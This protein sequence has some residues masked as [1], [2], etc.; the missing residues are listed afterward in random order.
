VVTVQSR[1]PTVTA[2][3]AATV[4]DVSGGRCVVGIGSGSG[5]GAAGL[6]SSG[7]DSPGP[8]AVVEEYARVVKSAL[9]GDRVESELFG[10]RGFHLGLDFG[11]RPRPGVWLAALGERMVSLA[12]RLADGVL[13]NWCTPERVAAARR[14]LA[15]AAERAG[16]DPAEV[17]VAVYA[18]GALEVDEAAAL[19]GLR[20]MT[21]MYASFPAY[22]RQFAA[23]GYANEAAA[24]AAAH[25]DGRPG[26]VPDALVRAL[27]VTGGR[28][29]AVARFRAFHEAGADLVLWYPVAAGDDPLGSVRATV[30]AAAPAPAG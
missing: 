13:L 8:L 27:T 2:M 21:G 19:A 18:R 28:A 25:R 1:T 26:D 7:D 17:T 11:E 14:T 29:E 30:L 4:H 15:E 5:R 3:G 23:M 6:A 22:G 24:A 20:A 10:V 16:R 9:A 12:G